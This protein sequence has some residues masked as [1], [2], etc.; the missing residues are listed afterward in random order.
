M[1]HLMKERNSRQ[2]PQSDEDT[3]REHQDFSSK[4][5]DLDD[6]MQQQQQQ[7]HHGLRQMDPTPSGSYSITGIL[8]DQTPQHGLNGPTGYDVNQ[9][10]GQPS[11]KNC[12]QTMHGQSPNMG[13][14]GHHGNTM[15]GNMVDFARYQDAPSHPFTDIQHVRAESE[16]CRLNCGLQEVFGFAILFDNLDGCFAVIGSNTAMPY[17]VQPLTSKW[18]GQSADSYKFHRMEMYFYIFLK[19]T[20]TSH[21]W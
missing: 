16:E 13:M 17:A 7:Q 8:S 18:V 6:K 20:R 11:Q 2:P 9:C 10:G 12:P 1:E 19:T 21:E 5:R 14:H 3:T 4:P 15:A